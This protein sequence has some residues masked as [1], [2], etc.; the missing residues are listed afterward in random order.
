MLPGQGSSKSRDLTALVSVGG[1]RF[2]RRARAA[3]RSPSLVVFT[4]ASHGQ[5]FRM[6]RQFVDAMPPRPPRAP[7]GVAVIGVGLSRFIGPPLARRA[8]R[9]DLAPPASAPRLHPW[10]RHL[11]DARPPLPLSR[12]YEL[13][14]RWMD[15]RWAGFREHRRANLR[16]LARLVEACR[17]KGL[18][19]VLVDLPLD[20]RVVG[21]GLDRARRSYGTAVRHIARAQHV[22]YLTPAGPPLPTNDFWDLMHLLPPGAAAW[23]SRLSDR[24]VR[25][26]PPP[27]AR[28]RSDWRPR[29]R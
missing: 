10:I 1:S 2:R 22:S 16:A 29:R 11:Y 5:T 26:L 20:V 7:R 12:K 13:V 28:R 15:R 8:A 25:L 27:M 4:I 14:P 18:E 9:V 24:L 23:Q 3:G 21:H 17:A 19:P 6:D